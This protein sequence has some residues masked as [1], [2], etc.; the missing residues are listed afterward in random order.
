MQFS[1]EL[2]IVEFLLKAL[3]EAIICWGAKVD[4]PV[5][6]F[7]ACFCCLCSGVKSRPAWYAAHWLFGTA[8]VLLGFYN[9]YTG[10]HAYELMSG[11]SLRTINILFSIQLSF[12]AF[13]YLTQ[14]RWQYFLEQGKFSKSVTPT[15]NE[16]KPKPGHEAHIEVIPTA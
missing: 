16:Q 15:Y 7:F 13:V 9:I 2:E 5:S 3:S 6:P 10:M 12:V 11:K 8:G 14:D 1:D 4:S